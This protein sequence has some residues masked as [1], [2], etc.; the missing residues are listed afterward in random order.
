MKIN[1][2]ENLKTTYFNYHFFFFFFKRSQI[3]KNRTVFE[4]LFKSLRVGLLFIF[5]LSFRFPD[6]RFELI[7]TF[8]NLRYHRWMHIRRR[9]YWD[10]VGEFLEESWRFQPPRRAE[11]KKSKTLKRIKTLEKKE[12]FWGSSDLR[13]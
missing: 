9:H 1:I 2:N 8:R 12:M 11:N 3:N 7:L 13:E 5:L 4:K 10:W 6:F